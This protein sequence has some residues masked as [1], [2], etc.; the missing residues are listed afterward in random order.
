MAPA[1]PSF[2]QAEYAYRTAYSTRVSTPRR[3]LPTIGRPA[4][5]AVGT[6]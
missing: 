2:S 6:R 5:H 1:I 3:P 4:G